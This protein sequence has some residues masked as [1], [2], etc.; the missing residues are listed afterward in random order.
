LVE[1][2]SG[3]ESLDALWAL[4]LSGG[5]NEARALKLLQHS[6]PF[7]RLWTVRLICDEGEVSAAMAARLAEVALT[8]PHL[9]ARSQLACSARRLPTRQGLPIVRNLL[10]RDEDAGDIHIPL[11]LWWAIESKAGTDRDA[12]VDLF[13]ET[14]LW[15]KPIVA[16][17]IVE[18]LMRRFAQAG[19]QYDLLACA[20]L[21]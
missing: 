18:R 1:S 4:N 19:T 11:L 2:S 15:Q 21:L 6:D 13:R 10:V 9:E 3:Q 20:T 8:E 16:Q 14:D 7:V 12:I 5:L 17:H